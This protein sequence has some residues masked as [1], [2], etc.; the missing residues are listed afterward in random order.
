MVAQQQ[1]GGAH[2]DGVRVV[3][4]GGGAP[5][6]VRHP[7]ADRRPGRQRG[8]GHRLPSPHVRRAPAVGEPF[9]ADVPQTGVRGRGQADVAADVAAAVAAEE[10][11]RGR[12]ECMDAAKQEIDTMRTKTNSGGGRDKER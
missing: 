7:A 11:G 8:R 4:G 9:H 3:R 12:R 6:R 5:P 2:P 1:R 10:H